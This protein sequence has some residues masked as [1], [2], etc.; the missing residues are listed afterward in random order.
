MA[1][2]DDCA[3][4]QATSADPTCHQHCQPERTTQAEAHTV[5]VPP[6]GLTAVA[7]MLLSMATVALP[8]RGALVRFDRQHAP[9]PEPRWL[10]CTL[11][12]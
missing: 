5:S 11:L 1:M 7:P 9:P 8:T 2:G 4:V 6:N 12:I 10:F 3:H